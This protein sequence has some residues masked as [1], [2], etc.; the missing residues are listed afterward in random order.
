MGDTLAKR[1]DDRRGDGRGT[2]LGFVAHEVRNPLSTA[3][4]TAELLTRMPPD[5]RAGARGDKLAAMCLR[6]LGRL[7]QLVEDH[8]L[9]ERLD[10]GGLP[11]RPEPVALGEAIDAVLARLPGVSIS[12]DVPPDLAAAADRA[13]VERALDAILRAASRDGVAVRV[14]ARAEGALAE[15][16][17]QGAPPGPGALDDP[18][19]GTASD[20]RGSALGLAAARRIGEALG[21]RL[22][23]DGQAY[24]LALPRIDAPPADGGR[25]GDR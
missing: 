4:W 8:L 6:S 9:I 25:P 2:Y 17:V 18:R 12:A 21:G 10:A 24:L 19:K 14:E 1:H 15:V 22:A 5:E 3:L 13:L 16:R 20:P 11:L 7:R 23:V